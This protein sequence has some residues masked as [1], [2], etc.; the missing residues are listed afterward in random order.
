MGRNDLVAP[1]S[2]R[3]VVGGHHGVLGTRREPAEV[4]VG[5]GI[6]HVAGVLR[7]EALARRLFG[8]AHGAPDLGPRRTRS[9]GLVDEVSDQVVGQLVE[10]VGRDDGGRELFEFVVVHR[11]DGGDEVVETNG[12]RQR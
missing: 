5:A 11:A 3:R 10:V 7:Q 8:D 6:V 4:P 1:G 12:C 9:T 2:V